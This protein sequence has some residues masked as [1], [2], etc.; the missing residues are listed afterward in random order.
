MKILKIS[1]I[2]LIVSILSGCG[3]SKA[4]TNELGNSSEKNDSVNY[5]EETK[6]QEERNKQTLWTVLDTDGN[7]KEMVSEKN[8]DDVRKI[9]KIINDH[10]TLVD[11]RDFKELKVENEYNLY[12]DKF[13]KVLDKGDY[14]KSVQAMYE[15]NKLAL[16]HEN[17]IWYRNYFNEDMTTCKV[18]VESEFK[19]KE[20]NKEY[21]EKN[22]MNLKEVYQEKRI[23]YLEKNNNEWK[24]INIEKGALTKRS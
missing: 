4:N 5:D 18:T 15:S 6:K 7:E 3:V 17:L 2:F 8:S 16:K 12:N 19:I 14:K 1:I 13:S 21:L 10:C 9:K 11:N 20:S 23:Y 22:K 24:I